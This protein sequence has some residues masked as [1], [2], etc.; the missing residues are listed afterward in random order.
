MSPGK[1]VLLSTSKTVRR[2]MSRWDVSGDGKAS[3]VE[4]DVRDLGGHLDLTFRARAGTLSKR[5]R[6]GTYGVAAVGPLPLGFKVKLGL[7]KGKYLLA[8]LHAVEASHVS[9]SLASVRAAI[10]RAVW[11]SKMPMASASAI[12][13][14]LDGPSGFD[15]AFYVWVRFHMMR[16]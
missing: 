3:K 5:V 2:V 15:P 8:G 1:C 7:V 13:S 16:R 12:L 4:L 9:I 10:G 14:L 6:D 11:S